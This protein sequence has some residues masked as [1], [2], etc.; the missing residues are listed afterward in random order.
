M[1]GR[2]LNRLITKLIGS[3][4]VGLILAGCE[5]GNQ[6]IAPSPTDAAEGLQVPRT[7]TLSSPAFRLDGML[8]AKHTCDGEN[9]SPALSWDAP[10]AATRSLALLVNDIDAPSKTFVHWVLYDLPPTVRQL[11]EKLPSQPFLAI[12]GI[13]GKNDFGQYGYGGACPPSGTHRY[14][15]RLFALDTLL[16]LPPGTTKSEVMEAMK[17]HI[18][19]GAELTG[20][21]KRK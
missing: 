16:D 4:L 8:P 6:A 2:W 18:V 14:V 10:P 13:Q 3:A 1:S 12:G 5:T 17:G 9:I 11:P 21:Y 19:A 20:Q 15:F 7:M